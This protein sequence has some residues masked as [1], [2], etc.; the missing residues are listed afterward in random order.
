MTAD[1]P[2]L[3]HLPRLMLGL[4][5]Q[6]TMPGLRHLPTTGRVAGA[7]CRIGALHGAHR[8]TPITGALPRTAGRTVA[9]VTTGAEQGGH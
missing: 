6:L 7:S 2:H 4:H 3:P 9:A 8:R 1:F 5:P